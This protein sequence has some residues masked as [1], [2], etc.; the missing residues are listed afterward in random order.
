MR[1]P[2]PQMRSAIMVYYVDDRFWHSAYG[3]QS[4]PMALHVS[5]NPRKRP[6]ATVTIAG[7]LHHM[8]AYKASFRMAGPVYTKPRSREQGV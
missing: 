4:N 5:T 6:L 8:P 2:R 7:T 1:P 3:I